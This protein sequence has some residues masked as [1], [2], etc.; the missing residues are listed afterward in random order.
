MPKILIVILLVACATAVGFLAWRGTS[1]AFAQQPAAQQQQDP[2]FMQSAIQ[3]LQ[4][5]RNQALDQVA[6]LQ[7][8]LAQSQSDAAR[9]RDE[10]SKKEKPSDAGAPKDH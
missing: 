9:L 4:A 5:Q 6:A 7:A 8:Q 2:V 1:S 3:A 10:L